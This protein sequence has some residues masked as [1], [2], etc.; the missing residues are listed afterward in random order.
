MCQASIL[1]LIHSLSASVGYFILAAISKITFPVQ[2]VLIFQPRP[3]FGPVLL[4]H[5]IGPGQRDPSANL[6]GS[7]YKM[8]GAYTDLTSPESQ[9]WVPE[10]ALPPSECPDP[11]LGTL[12]AGEQ[13]RDGICGGR[14]LSCYHS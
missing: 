3:V 4:S 2:F 10:M 6:L 5:W 14:S 8:C 7:V 12:V 9:S 11:W 13:S 1:P